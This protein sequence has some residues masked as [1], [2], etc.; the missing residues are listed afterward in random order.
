[1]LISIWNLA[2]HDHIPWT[3]WKIRN[4]FID[5]LIYVLLAPFVVLWLSS[6]V[7]VPVYVRSLS[8]ASDDAVDSLEIAIR[9]SS[10]SMAMSSAEKVPIRLV[11]KRESHCAEEEV[12]N[13]ENVEDGEEGKRMVYDADEH[14]DSKAHAN[15]DQLGKNQMTFKRRLVLQ[16]K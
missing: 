1:M 11:A 10:D 12:E 3:R 2:T 6:L 16:E 9:D 5:H 13:E 15:F 14:Q 8:R 7:S 4:W